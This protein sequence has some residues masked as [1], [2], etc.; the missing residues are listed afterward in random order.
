ML[1]DKDIALGN[2]CWVRRWDAERSQT[3]VGAHLMAY[4]VIDERLKLMEYVFMI[5]WIVER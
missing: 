1:F 3:Y 4:V 5:L 2:S